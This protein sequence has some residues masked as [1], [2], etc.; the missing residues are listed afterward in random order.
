MYAVFKTGGKQY[1]ASEGERLKIEKLQLAEGDTVEFTDVLAIGEGSA[2]TVGQPLVKGARVTGKVIAQ[3]RHDKVSVIK[4]RRR[5]NYKRM[6]GHRQA[7]TM[8]EITD[9]AAR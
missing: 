5:K 9:I 6:H 7:F 4:F 1:R 8:V 3:D 2:L